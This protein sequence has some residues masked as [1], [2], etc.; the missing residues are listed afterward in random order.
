MAGRHCNPIRSWNTGEAEY[1]LDYSR[2]R[3]G[4]SRFPLFPSARQNDT[5][6]HDILRLVCHRQ[7]NISTGQKQIR[8][9]NL[10]IGR[11]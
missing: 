11:S 5:I 2:V 3:A 8:F 1:L 10:V 6:E 4:K 9:Q 7:Y